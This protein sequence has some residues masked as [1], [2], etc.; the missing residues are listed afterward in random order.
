MSRKLRERA[1]TVGAVVLLL[2]PVVAVAGLTPQGLTP[3][4]VA[5]MGTDILSPDLKGVAIDH[6]D[7]LGTSSTDTTVVTHELTSV[8]GVSTGLGNYIVLPKGATPVGHY[9]VAQLVDAG[10]NLAEKLQLYIADE[11]RDDVPNQFHRADQQDNQDELYIVYFY[12]PWAGE[13][14]SLCPYNALTKS[15]SA[16]AIA[17]KP[18]DLDATTRNS[19]YF[20]CTATGV[21]SKCA[22]NWLPAVGHD[23]GLR[24][25][26]SGLGARG[27]GPR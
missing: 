22:R 15:A 11:Q 10:G 8:P 21:A 4:G 9:A 23:A 1:F 27:P 20:A 25:S 5:L 7:I 12:Y 26:Q 24:V 19:F 3:Q 16:M 18:H 13:W 17:E 2:S 14:I 6:V